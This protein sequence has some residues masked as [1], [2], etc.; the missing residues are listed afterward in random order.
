MYHLTHNIQGFHGRFLALVLAVSDWDYGASILLSTPRT[1]MPDSST[2]KYHDLPF[3]IRHIF[4]ESTVFLHAA[5][6][7]PAASRFARLTMAN[8]P[9]STVQWQSAF[10]GIAAI[11]LNTILQP[12][13]SVCHLPPKYQLSLRSSPLFCLTDTTTVIYD[14]AKKAKHMSLRQAIRTVAEFRHQHDT[15]QE[16]SNSLLRFISWLFMAAAIVQAV[17][18]FA[19]RGL[20]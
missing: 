13:G 8:S 17:K 7:R 6:G 19:C 20:S 18:L 11:F 2:P 12:A 14:I 5:C 1:C 15:D 9:T 3:F 16:N 4:R 10:W